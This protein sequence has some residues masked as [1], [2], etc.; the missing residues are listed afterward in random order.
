M[1]LNTAP[2]PGA[3]PSFFERTFGQ[4]A[5]NLAGGA[6]SV[7]QRDPAEVW[8]NVGYVVETGNEEQPT[9]FVSLPGGI[10]IDTMKPIEIKSRNGD[11][12]SFLSARNELLVKVQSRASQLK[13]GEEVIY[14]V[15]GG[16]ALQLRRVN[17]PVVA[18]AADD[19]NRFVKSIEL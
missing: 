4:N 14:D 15:G 2:A 8:M 5:G 7:E 9:M 11:Y 10:A 1:S 13:P 16:L 19:T 17:D 18:P 12:A 3:A 6:S